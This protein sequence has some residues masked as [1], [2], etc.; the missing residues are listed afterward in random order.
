MKPKKDIYD[1]D[2]NASD[3]EI[4][5][6]TTTQ[7]TSP[8]KSLRDIANKTFTRTLLTLFLLL[9]LFGSTFVIASRMTNQ[10]FTTPSADISYIPQAHIDFP[11]I[12]AD[13]IQPT[14]PPVIIKSCSEIN[15]DQDIRSFLHSFC[16]GDVCQSQS[17]KEACES[18][19]VLVLQ[20][21]G[22]LSTK[23][24]EDG[25]IDCVWNDSKSICETRY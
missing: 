23:S 7:K 19:D 4:F 3:L 12:P 13:T 20:E 18:I 16:L 2:L 6:T 9:F 22:Y 8:N 25:I 21:D 14:P 5:S 10:S 17:T 1:F 11:E 24:G 15:K